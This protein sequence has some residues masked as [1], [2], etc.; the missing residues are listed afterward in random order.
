M[1]VPEE[2][3]CRRQRPFLAKFCA[4]IKGKGDCNKWEPCYFKNGKCKFLAAATLNFRTFASTPEWFEESESGRPKYT[5]WS[6]YLRAFDLFKEQAISEVG[7]GQWTKPDN[8]VGIDVCS[9]HPHGF[10]C[11]DTAEQR[12]DDPQCKLPEN[13]DD[14]YSTCRK[15]CDGVDWKEMEK[16]TFWYCGTREK[17]GV[18]GSIEGGMG[19]WM[20][21][22]EKPMVSWLIPGTT[23]ANYEVFGG[24]FLAD[25]AQPCINMGGAVRISNRLLVPNDALT[26][27][28]P[29]TPFGRD[30][31]LGY[32][33]QRTPLGKRAPTDTANY[34]TIIV[35]AGNFAG[36][37]MIISSWFWDMRTNWH[38]KSTSWS[39]PSVKIGQIQEGLSLGGY[40]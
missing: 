34:W 7:W 15:H 27:E 9:V 2:K 12:K 37:V 22:I 39:D 1:F 23:S 28:E 20:Y 21:H 5:G 31:M 25:R 10:M 13:D 4:T 32:M 24:T 29:D 40:V 36:P 18:R 17:G 26:F 30:G 14:E 38:P 19:Y 3:K 11:E 6:Y 8:G 16:C 35:D 33:L